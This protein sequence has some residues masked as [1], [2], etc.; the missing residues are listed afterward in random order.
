[1]DIDLR[2]LRYFV[3]VAEEL[4]F[5]RAAKRLYI[6]QPVLSR[7]IRA[8]EHE[9]GAQLFSRNKR[10]T[11][12]TP[13]GHQLLED[14][15]PLLASAAALGRRIEQAAHGAPTFTVGFMPGIIVTAAVRVL[16]ARHP[17]L[18][19]GVLRTSWDDQTEVVHNGRADVS[20]VRMPV[21]RQGLRLRPLFS[22][23]RVAVLSADHR[24]ADKQS[25][26]VADLAYERLLQNPDAVPEW[27]DLPE[28]P[29]AE[30]AR[31]AFTGV[32]E[33]LE[34]IATSGGV[35]VLPLSTATFYTRS[36]IV[37]V[38]IEDIGP[39]QVCLAWSADRRSPLIEEFA[40]IA[41]DQA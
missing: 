19:I 34:H 22:E 35:V 40:G 18:S 28:R 12:L 10:S 27:R 25:I 37:H 24:L 8:L 23:P 1:M 7:Q 33:K 5:G 2:K 16:A 39:N 13:A 38:S 17:E 11:E 9:L 20:F 3:A 31:P 30:P 36:D 26:G 4:H 29:K 32:E 14:A 15:R 21:D 41:G 6:T